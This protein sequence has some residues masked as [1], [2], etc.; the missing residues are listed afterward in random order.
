MPFDD[1]Y[2]RLDRG[3]LDVERAQARDEGRD[4]GRLEQAFERVRERLGDSPGERQNEARALCEQIRDRPIR[5]GYEY[6]EPSALAGI[7][8]ERPD[9]P[10]RT[11]VPGDLPDR[12]HGA[13]LGRCC[14]CL[15]GKPVEGWTADRLWGF[16]Q[17]T[18]TDPLRGYLP[19]DVPAD[20]RETYG[21]DDL[22][23]YLDAFAEEI[24]HM[25][26]DDDLDYTVAAL[27]VVS[28]HG[29]GFDTGDVASVWLENLPVMKTFTAERIAYRNLL[30]LREPPETA[31]H[32]NPY[33]EGIGAQ[34]RA[35]LYGY[36][37]AGN[38]ELAAELAWRDARLSHVR[39]GTYGAMWVA[40]ML[41]VAPVIDDPVDV[42]RTGLTEVPAESRLAEA[43]GDV[44]D[45]WAADLAYED[46]VARV[47]DRWDDTDEYE[48]L[49]VLSNAQVVA[50][51]LLW[52]EGEFAASVGSAVQ[53]GFDTDCNGA[54]VGSVVGMARG[55][56]SVPDTWTA[57]LDDTLETALADRPVA[58]VSELA[59]ETTALCE[60]SR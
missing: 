4:V 60:R 54:T 3:V 56:A 24:P 33:R 14:G 20:V 45:W 44:L 31:R 19:A 35:D 42:V 51:G 22:P 7:R 43:V 41:A 32:C 46:A 15:L 49:H 28:E 47:H 27:A 52:G 5:D 23:D 10:R 53:A 59:R 40:A 48:W 11:D 2:L 25:V 18:D 26:R 36:V 29:P 38:P 1:T 57:P 55:A 16:L 30:D 39:N 6:T 21:L 8:R 34:I 9:G 17:A 58:S 13:W 50:I 37:C 12:I